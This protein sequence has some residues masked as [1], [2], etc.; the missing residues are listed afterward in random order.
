MHSLSIDVFKG[1]LKN[2]RRS[3]REFYQHFHGYGLSICLRYADNREEAVDILNEAFMVVFKNI[4]KYDL[5]RPFIP[6]FRKILINLCINS[7]KRKNIRFTED[8]EKA[9]D[10]ATNEEILSGISFEEILKIIRQLSP[11]YRTV[12]NLYVI[13]GYKHEEIATILGISVGTSKSNL[14]KA[15]KIL[16]EI[17]KD[18]FMEDYEHAGQR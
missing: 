18:Y 12:F 2:D 7:F 15:K 3:Q 14:F 1:C 4:N 13:E 11:A 8:L 16:Q 17:L 10:H 6:W 9:N 5:N